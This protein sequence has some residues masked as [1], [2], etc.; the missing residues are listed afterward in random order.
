MV[1]GTANSISDVHA[2]AKDHRGQPRALEL[3]VGGAW[4]VGI[5]SMLVTGILF[6]AGLP[7][8][9][10]AYPGLAWPLLGV[11]FISFTVARILQGRYERR[12]P[13]G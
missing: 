11:A 7:E 1:D 13:L 3:W 12:S 6:V 5:C 10:P 2:R 4:I 8:S 9:G